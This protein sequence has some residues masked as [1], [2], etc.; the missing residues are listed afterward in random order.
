MNR[1]HKQNDEHEDHAHPSQS[2]LREYKDDGQAQPPSMFLFRLEV[3]AYWL[4][5]LTIFC[6]IL[7]GGVFLAFKFDLFTDEFEGSVQRPDFVGDAGEIIIPK[8]LESYLAAVG[9]REALES[10]QSVRYKGLLKEPSSD[11]D[12]QI[13]MSLPDKGMIITDPGNGVRHKLVLNGQTAWQAIDF[14]D[15]T[16]KILALNAANTASLIWSLQVHNTFRRL[17][18]KRSNTDFS[19]R[20]IQFLDKPC[21]QLIKLMPNGTTFEAV[22]DA[23]TLY[24]LKTEETVPGSQGMERLQVLYSDHRKDFDI[25]EPY[26]TK[27]YKNGELYNEVFLESIE[28]DPGLISALFKVPEELSK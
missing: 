4:L 6:I 25:V 11:V 9:G 22:L 2:P 21:Y 14:G 13:L 7:A 18:L 12:F 23:K 5:P 8:L 26:A 10:F 15:G 1:F 27:T 28:R 19:A 16:R 17:A 3:T 20:E 24:L